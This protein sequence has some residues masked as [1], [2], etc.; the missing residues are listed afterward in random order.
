MLKKGFLIILILFVFTTITKSEGDAAGEVIIVFGSD[1]SIWDGMSTNTFHDNYNLQLFV[2][3]A[4]NAYKVMR[5]EWRQ[6]IKDSYGNTV[7]FTWWMMAGQ[8]FRYAV[9]VNVPI[10]NTMG[11]YLMKLHHGEA[12]KQFGDELSLHYHT[13]NWTDYN[14][15]GVF[16]WNQAKTFNEC[17]A[18]FD[19]TLAQYLLEENTF[20]VSFRSGWHYMDND[21]QNYL[22]SLL[23]Y[24]M[25]NDYPAKRYVENEPIDNVYDWSECSKF[26]VPF[27]PS[28]NNYQHPGSL[29]SW[30]LR[31]KHIGSVDL[32]LLTQM[33]SKANGGANQVACLWGHLPEEDFLTNIGRIDSLAHFLQAKYPAVKFRYCTAIEAMQR[34]QKSNDTKAPVVSFAEKNSSDDVI[35]TIHTDEP[36]FQKQ[37]FVAV[38]DIY[39]RYIVVPCRQTG[40]N[41]WETTQSFPR[42]ILAK[43]G[44]A[45]TDTVGNQTLS[46]IKYMQDDLYIDD[47]D[48]TSYKEMRGAWQT[49]TA[50]SYFNQSLRTAAI[51]PG[52]SAVVELSP[53]LEKSGN[54]NIFFQTQ[55]SAAPVEHYEFI[56]Y[57]NGGAK[58]TILVNSAITPSKWNLIAVKTLS[59]GDYIDIIYKNDKSSSVTAFADVFKISPLVKDKQITCPNSVINMGTFTEMDTSFL[60]KFQMANNG[61][62]QL[63]I[64]GIK[65][66][67]GIIVPAVSTPITI[68][69]NGSVTISIRLT[70]TVIGKYTDTL[71]ITSDDPITPVYQLPCNAEVSAYFEAPDNEDT[72]RYSET[73]KWFYSNAYAFG[74]T[75]RYSWLSEPAGAK[76]AY[77]TKIRKTGTYEFFEIVPKTENAS[78][79]ALY[80]IKINGK[81]A[82]SAYLDQNTGSGTWVSIGKA[83]IKTGDTAEVQVINDGSNTSTTAVVLRADAVKIQFID[84]ANGVTNT[85]GNLP[86]SYSLEPN[87]PNPFNST[88]ILKFSLPV[89]SGVILKVY[90]VLGRCVR[91]IAD[92]RM[93]GGSYTM[94]FNA[95]GMASG[96]Y[97]VQ[98]QAGNF[99]ASRKILYLK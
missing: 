17:R 50:N 61:I 44:V 41:S 12:V 46:Y 37:P 16:Y 94:P 62:E 36:I 72:L 55:N 82:F 49:L 66:A 64:D 2:D 68:N 1:T 40:A 48:N 74:A 53:Q 31:S 27:H 6:N 38:K 29:K 56:I 43:A 4:F 8:I 11:L 85:G 71:F 30:N 87:F 51:N 14:G 21:W 73:G 45:L 70:N 76:A 23:L 88:T 7:K 81:S 63:K 25:H 47:K 75:S 80:Q 5:P 92:G 39:E 9:N 20:P 95:A 77:K 3:P 33:F 91:T 57:K 79:K 22:D 98:M 78:S 10:A 15:D 28:K 60:Y 65:S 54:Y 35:Y 52:D 13:F 86:A 42:K 59:P 83:Y 34:F 19:F 26:F 96:M 93:K 99:S 58:D 89:E 97:I 67:S 84:P 24:C 69:G 18:D 32:S 90:D